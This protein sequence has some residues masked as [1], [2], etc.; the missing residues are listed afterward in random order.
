MMI[1]GVPAPLEPLELAPIYLLLLFMMLSQYLGVVIYTMVNHRKDHRNAD[2]G[3][4]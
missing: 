3:L 1:L 4:F 2:L